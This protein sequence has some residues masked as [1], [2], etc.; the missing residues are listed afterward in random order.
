MY[1][2][3]AEEQ[4]FPG[5]QTYFK[6]TEI[7]YEGAVGEEDG[8]D[9]YTNN[10]HYISQYLGIICDQCEAYINEDFGYAELNDYATCCASSPDVTYTIVDTTDVTQDDTY[11]YQVTVLGNTAYDTYVS[12][13]YVEYYWPPGCLDQDI[14]STNTPASWDDQTEKTRAYVIEAPQGYYCPEQCQ[15]PLSCPIGNYSYNDGSVECTP[16]E[17]GYW[18]PFAATTLDKYLDDGSGTGSL[19]EDDGSGD[20]P[21]T[22]AD[23][24]RIPCPRG[25]WCSTMVLDML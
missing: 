18:C 14:I 15:E 20:A 21:F 24:H 9:P 10:V 13:G 4:P 12:Y 17:V 1:C 8:Y 25:F 3:G 2:T 19:T 22:I 23:N 6:L 11:T 7:T 16:C 5:L